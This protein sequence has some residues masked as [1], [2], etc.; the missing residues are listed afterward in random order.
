MEKNKTLDQLFAKARNQETQYS[1]NEVSERFRLALTIGNES[2]YA[3]NESYFTLKFWIMVCSA[4][5]LLTASLILFSEKNERH[6]NASEKEQF[7]TTVVDSI[8]LYT[9]QNPID[10]RNLPTEEGP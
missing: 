5:A 2:N 7:T 8:A 10:S 9:R 4:A 3:N 6:L 1:L